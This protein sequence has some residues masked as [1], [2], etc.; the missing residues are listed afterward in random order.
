VA[1]DFSNA[2]FSVRSDL[3]EALRREWE[4]LAAPG[5]WWSASERVAI[6]AET[7]AA[8]LGE[9]AA[10]GPTSILSAGVLDVV[11]KVAADSPLITAEWVAALPGRGVD[12]PAYAEIVGVVARLSSVDRFHR[13]L[14]LA[15]EPLP[16]P[17][18]GEPSRT[19]AAAEG[20]VEGESYI[21]MV[22]RVAIPQTISLVPAE[23]AAWYALSDAMYMTFKEMDD[24]DFR[25]AMHRTQIELVAARTSQINECF[26]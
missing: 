1:F 16:E 26:Y 25:R 10:S 12:L 14:G 5:T 3:Q 13:A 7:R 2:E 24:P 23:T 17:Q 19:P 18:A 9:R 6:A 8:M 4:F 11:W 21:P 22:G 20:L 15:L